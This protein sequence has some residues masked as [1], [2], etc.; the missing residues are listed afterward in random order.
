MQTDEVV[1]VTEKDLANVKEGFFFFFPSFF[2][3]FFFV[4]CS[5]NPFAL[6]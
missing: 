6:S 5:H 3:F 1:N 2:F 4:S